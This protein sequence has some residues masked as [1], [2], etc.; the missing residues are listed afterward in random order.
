VFG[1]DMD[2][3]AT[4]DDCF[5]PRGVCYERSDPS[6][7]FD[8]LL[9]VV[10]HEQEFL[11]TEEVCQRLGSCLPWL[12]VHSE[13]LGDRRKNE[14]RVREGSERY[15]EDP[16]GK[17]VD[18]LR[19]QLKSETRLAGA[20]RPGEGEQANV[21]SHQQQQRVLHFPVAADEQRRLNGQVRRAILEC[22]WRR[23]V[24]AHSL[25]EQLMETLGL[26]QILQAMIA[27]IPETRTAEIL[28]RDELVDRLGD[29]HLPAVRRRGDS[30]SSMHRDSHIFPADE[31][32]LARVETHAD[33][34]LR[35]LPPLCTR[36]PALAVSRGGEG[37]GGASKRNKEGVAFGVHFP[38][39]MCGDHFAEQTVVLPK[40]GRVRLATQFAQQPSRPLDVREQEGD[41]AGRE[42]RRRYGPQA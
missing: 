4:R 13:R 29:E 31:K 3:R 16:V 5:H 8:H 36:D 15:E 35:S 12:L 14:L 33:M 2:R 42:L 38:T 17:V 10:E 26:A 34:D 37:V 20:A 11:L 28:V 27:E 23:E 18:D 9:E 6:S 41:R 22:P 39:M 19:G 7:G 25:D 30:R 32:S 21:S 24:R 1:G 40:D